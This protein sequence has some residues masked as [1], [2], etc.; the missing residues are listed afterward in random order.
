MTNDQTIRGNQG[1]VVGGDLHAQAVAAGDNAKAIV[2]N[3]T[4]ADLAEFRSSVS[5]LRA[6]LD[7]LSVPPNTKALVSKHVDDL[8][9]ESEKSTPDRGRVATIL[10]AI[11]SSAKMLGDFVSNATTILG[12]LAK[13][14]ALFGFVLPI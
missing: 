12:P 14:A 3:F 9:A 6:A 8:A 5:E 10:G 13:I 2:N 7:A 11:A 4:A 1:I